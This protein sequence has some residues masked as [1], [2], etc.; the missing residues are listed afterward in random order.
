[1]PQSYIPHLD[2]ACRASCHLHV[3]HGSAAPAAPIPMPTR[4]IY[5]K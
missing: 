1:M 4:S 2:F 5:T 3:A